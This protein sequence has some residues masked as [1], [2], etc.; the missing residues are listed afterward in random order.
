MQRRSLSVRVVSRR[1][2]VFGIE[3]FSFNHQGHGR[4]CHGFS[5]PQTPYYCYAIWQTSVSRNN[6]S[7][8]RTS[9]SVLTFSLLSGR[10]LGKIF[11]DYSTLNE[12]YFRGVLPREKLFSFFQG[13]WSK[14][15]LSSI[16]NVPLGG[17]HNI[18]LISQGCW[19]EPVRLSV[20]RFRKI[21]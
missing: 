3:S 20:H 2:V 5:C 14:Y 6:L 4:L 11:R 21:F 7:G 1:R 18:L 17:A 8:K 15:G 16:V 10:L 19:C 12:S 13:P 9:L